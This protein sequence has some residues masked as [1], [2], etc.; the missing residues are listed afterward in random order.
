MLDYIF[1][2]WNIPAME[3]QSLIEMFIRTILA[4]FYIQDLNFDNPVSAYVL[5]VGYSPATKKSI[6]Y[7]EANRYERF[8]L[9]EMAQTLGY[10]KHYLCSA[11]SQDTGVSI[12]DYVHFLKIRQAIVHFFY[13]GTDLTQVCDLLSFDSKSYFTTL[14]KTLTGISPGAFRKACLALTAENR[15]KINQSTLLFT[16]RPI[17]IDDLFASMHQLVGSITSNETI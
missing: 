8:S 13:W 11:F 6:A 12:L 1:Q 17:S 5:T 4:Q 7:T 3:N 9:E 14:F 16:S 2:Y 15:T 10:N